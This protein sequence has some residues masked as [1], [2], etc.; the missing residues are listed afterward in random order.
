MTST[1]YLEPEA[2]NALPRR[3]LAQ[4]VWVGAEALGQKREA[5]FASVVR[6]K[7]MIADGIQ[8]QGFR[9]SVR[10]S[11]TLPNLK[12]INSVVTS[13]TLLGSLTRLNGCFVAL[14]VEPVKREDFVRVLTMSYP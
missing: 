2:A 7:R 5:G 4:M 14:H 11:C 3:R 12:S 8:T 10:M 13:V 1:P 9:F 6:S